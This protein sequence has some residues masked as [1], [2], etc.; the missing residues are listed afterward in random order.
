VQQRADRASS[1]K[2]RR[3]GDAAALGAVKR[4]LAETG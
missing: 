4:W 1:P 2:W 3:D